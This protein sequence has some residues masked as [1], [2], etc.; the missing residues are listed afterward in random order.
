MQ[1]ESAWVTIGILLSCA[2]MGSDAFAESGS[3]QSSFAGAFWFGLAITYFTR[4][5]AIGGWL[6]YYYFQL[7]AGSVLL[8]LLSGANSE[9]WLPANW[10]DKALYTLFL[11]TLVPSYVLKALEIAV[12][13]ILLKRRFRTQKYINYLRY[14]L[15]TEAIVGGLAAFI[16]YSH[17]PDSLFFTILSSVFAIVWNL[18]FT[19][20]YRVYYVLAHPEWQW[21]HETFHQSKVQFKSSK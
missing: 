1:R 20:S 10:S 4:K 12:G 9:N 21:N 6:F 2:A 13:C 15:L 7:F 17:F 5:R 3:G 19:N 14:V 11:V 8:F 18:Y 16:D